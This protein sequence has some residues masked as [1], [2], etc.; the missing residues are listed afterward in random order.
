MIITRSE[1][2]KFQTKG[3]CGTAVFLCLLCPIWVWGQSESTGPDGSN[4]ESIHALGYEGQSVHIGLISQDHARYSH[5]AFDGSAYYYDATDQTDYLPSN[6]DTEVGGLLCSRGG[7]AYPDAIGLAPQAELYSYRVLRPK[8]DADPNYVYNNNWIA[9]ALSEAQENDCRVIVT[10]IQLSDTADASSFY[11][12]LY[13]YYAYT[14]NMIFA[15]A[16]GNNYS[17]ITIFGDSYNSITT[18]GL[19]A[20]DT[21]PYG[22]VGS[23]SNPGPTVDGRRKP[24]VSAPSAGQRAPAASS[25]TAWTI[26][27]GTTQGYTSWAVPHTGGVAALLLNYAD[28]SSET[29]DDQNV[30]IKAVIVNSTFPNIDDADGQATVDITDPNDQSWVWNTDRGYGRIDG[31]RAMELLQSPRIEPETATDSLKGW[32]YASLQAAGQT[33][34]T[35]TDLKNERLVATLTWNRRVVWKDL[36]DNGVPQENELSPR[37][38]DLDLE[39]IAPD[40][41]VLISGLSEI[42]NLEKVDLQLTQSGDYEIRIVNNTTNE[43]ADF[44][45]AFELLEPIA[46]DVILDY[47]VDLRDLSELTDRWLQ[48]SDTASISGKIDLTDISILSQYWMKTDPRYYSAD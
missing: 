16:A 2:C 9:E 1:D 8:S 4:V 3:F 44:A 43:S 15:T 34:Y 40:A 38:A 24:E 30:V 46:G 5:E 10:G 35:L 20:S 47:I 27:S 17:A 14:Y 23:L 12:L 28:E 29:E 36:N 37:L 18:A 41:T 21:Q 13:D 11:A 7:E 48:T 32:D 45:L 39:I 25:D 42:D 26:V 33:S 6:H 31:Y 22:Q 19:I